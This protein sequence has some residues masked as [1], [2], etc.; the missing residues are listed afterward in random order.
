MYRGQ[1][2]H[3]PVAVKLLR[4][5][6]TAA[7]MQSF[8]NE[9]K[10]MQSVSH[11]HCL[12]F[13][14]ACKTND[15]LMLVTE[16]MH[17]SLGDYLQ[18]HKLSIDDQL[19]ICKEMTLGLTYLHKKKIVHLH[20]KASNFLVDAHGTVKLGKR[21]AQKQELGARMFVRSLTRFLVTVLQSC[22]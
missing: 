5:K 9:V 8:A 16:L 15:C 19:R 11:P 18:E 13:H 22:T 3:A 12:Q 2:H 6:L 4:G 1:Y 10:V 20:I 7:T 17:S 14:G 21:R